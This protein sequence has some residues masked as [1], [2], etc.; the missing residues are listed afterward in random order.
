[1]RYAPTS[2][3]R[4]IDTL[5]LFILAWLAFS[6]SSFG[7]FLGWVVLYNRFSI[8]KRLDISATRPKPK[9]N[10]RLALTRFSSLIFLSLRSLLDVHLISFLLYIPFLSLVFGFIFPVSDFSYVPVSIY[11]SLTYA[12]YDIL[13]FSQWFSFLF[14]S[15]DSFCLSFS[16]I[17]DTSFQTHRS[18]FLSILIFYLSSEGTSTFCIFLLALTLSPPSAI[19][20]S[21]LCFDMLVYPSSHTYLPQCQCQRDGYVLA[22]VF[23]CFVH[24]TSFPSLLSLSELESKVGLK[25]NSYVI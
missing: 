18:F 19:F 14:I 5:F 24:F 10:E 12:P 17:L 7:T 3:V 13:V 8:K 11:I 6:N 20:L 4:S 22:I 23:F 2:S 15:F 1:M 16:W 25:S 9:S 21:L